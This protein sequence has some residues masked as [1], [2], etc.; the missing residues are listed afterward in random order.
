MSIDYYLDRIHNK[1]KESSNDLYLDV[2]DNLE[3][4][5]RDFERLQDDYK[6]LSNTNE[7]L[8]SQVEIKGRAERILVERLDKHL[9]DW[10]FTLKIREAGVKK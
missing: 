1:V 9:P 8:Q 7:R 5:R 6:S 3:S 4:I 10:E 2:Y